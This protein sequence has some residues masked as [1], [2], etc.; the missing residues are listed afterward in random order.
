MTLREQWEVMKAPIFW[1][2]IAVLSAWAALGIWL[3]MRIGWPDSYGFHCHGKLCWM[4]DVWYSPLLLHNGHFGEYALFAWIWS[5]PTFLV[6]FIAWI[7]FP[8][9]GVHRHRPSH[10]NHR[11]KE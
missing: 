5:M 9:R 3:P 8:R 7:R 1:V 11:S 2:I 4:M 10:K 6:S